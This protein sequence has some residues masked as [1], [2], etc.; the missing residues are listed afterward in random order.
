MSESNKDF[1]FL[2]GEISPFN[3]K[4]SLNCIHAPSERVIELGEKDV[5]RGQKIPKRRNKIL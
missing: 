4:I 2:V 1:V 5:K 3:L